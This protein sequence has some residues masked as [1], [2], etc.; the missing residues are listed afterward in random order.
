MT[1][2]GPDPVVAVCD[3]ARCGA[4]MF[5]SRLETG[6]TWVARPAH[7]LASPTYCPRH[8]PEAPTQVLTQ[9]EDGSFAWLPDVTL[10]EIQLRCPTRS[11]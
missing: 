6:W 7:I 5:F 9:A 2:R 1:F 4:G 3:A 10:A 11:S 8:R